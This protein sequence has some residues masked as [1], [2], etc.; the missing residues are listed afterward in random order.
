MAV[1]GSRART[2][3]AICQHQ[4]R[5]AADNIPPRYDGGAVG[6]AGETRRHKKRCR[7]PEMCGGG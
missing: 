4:D 3:R 1:G 6:R 7:R 5:N 2:R